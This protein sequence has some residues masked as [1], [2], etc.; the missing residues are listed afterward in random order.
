MFY[1]LIKEKNQPRKEKSEYQI[2]CNA[3]IELYDKTEL[4]IFLHVY[5]FK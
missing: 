3:I 2:I 1:L 5:V 4:A